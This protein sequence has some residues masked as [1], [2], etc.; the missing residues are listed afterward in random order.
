MYLAYTTSGDKHQGLPTD[1]YHLAIARPPAGHALPVRGGRARHPDAGAG[2]GPPRTGTTIRR[3]ACWTERRTCSCS[4]TPPI[5]PRHAVHFEE[6]AT[7]ELGQ[8]YGRGAFALSERAK[9]ART[10]WT[11]SR[12]V[13]FVRPDSAVYS[14]SGQ[15]S[16]IR[17][18]CVV[19]C[20]RWATSSSPTCGS[21]GVGRHE[22]DRDLHVRRLGEPALL[23]RPR[24]TATGCG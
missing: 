12:P 9:R 23:A 14:A 4:D 18:N 10:P 21:R 6:R 5:P 7:G 16:T 1:G 24:R 11:V 17:S 3:A 8:G 13:P 2:R 15:R 22:E 19:V 20:R